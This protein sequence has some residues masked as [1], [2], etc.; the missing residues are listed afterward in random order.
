MV[1][2]VLSLV[3]IRQNKTVPPIEIAQIDAIASHILIAPSNFQV[4]ARVVCAQC[5]RKFAPPI[6]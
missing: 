4:R 1:Q 3:S 2:K 6:I 5:Y